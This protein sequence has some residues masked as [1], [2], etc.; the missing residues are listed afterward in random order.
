MS[1]DYKDCHFICLNTCIMNF[2]DEAMG[3]IPDTYYI[4]SLQF[5]SPDNEGSVKI[6][7]VKITL[8][9]K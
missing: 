8:L 7:W 5:N 4:S 9:E 6:D 3:F 2:D 1:R